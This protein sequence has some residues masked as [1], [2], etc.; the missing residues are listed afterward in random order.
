ML[1][2][3]IPS[4]GEPLPVIGLGTYRSFARYTAEL[5]TV[6]NL[7]FDAGGTMIDSSPMYGAAESVTGDVLDEIQGREKAFLATKV[8]TSGKQKGIREMEDSFQKMGA[9]STMELMQV[10]NLIDTD[11]HLDT[12]KG[13]KADGK[14]KYIGITHYSH[15]AF[16]EL[17]DWIRREPEIDFCQ[18]PYSIERRAAENGFLQLCADYGVATLINRP[19]EQDGLFSDILGKPLPDW[20]DEFGITSWSQYF[21]KYLLADEAVTCLIPATKSPGHMADNLRAGV[22]PMPDLAERK[23]MA[24][25][26]DS[27]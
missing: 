5:G 25:Y 8:W 26:F 24:V 16:R 15:S 18:F 11:A 12:L 21:L 3:P 13:W 1:T 10:H 22:G 7:M 27:L 17:G 9:G 20:A 4:T 23:R 14:I 19:F 6:V 2:R